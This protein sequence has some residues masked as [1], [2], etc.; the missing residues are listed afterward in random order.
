MRLDKLTIGSAKDSATHKFKNLK[1]VTID[2]DQDHWVTVVIGWNGTG[3][4]NVLEALAIIF[5]DLIAK[6]RISEFAFKLA[7]HMG[8]GENL[9]HIYIDADPDR[10]KEPFT[11]HIAT[12][13]EA[14]GEDNSLPFIEGE[15]SVPALRG[16]EIKFTDFLN[17]DSEHLPRYVFSYY[18]G[19]S[20]RMHEVFRPYLESYDSKL[21]NGEDPGLKRLFYAM[22][23]HSQ[24]VLLAFLI[25]QSDV[26][27]TFLDDHLGLDPD[28]G[29]ESVLFVL[30]QP[31]WKSEAVDGDPRFWNA[32]GVVRDFLSRLYDIA[33]AP[34]EVSR[35]VSTSIW[36][37]KKLQFKY[38]Y[39]K[40]IAALR[41]LVGDQAPAQFFR[42]LEST[43]VSELIE[44]VRIRV[45]LKKNDGSVTF[46]ELSEGE[47][48]LLTV[49]GLLRFTAEEESLFLLDEPDTHL[50]PRWCV[51]YLNYLKSF[52]GQ[53]SK[54]DDNS[55][56]ILTTHNPLAIAELVKEQVQIL[57]RE[58]GSRTVRA[59]NPAVDPKGMG[60]AGIVTSDMFGLGTS[61]D[62]AT[63]DDLMILHQLSTQQ[64]PLNE[65][66]RSKL[67]D[68]RQRLEGLDF[69]FASRDRLEQEYLRARFDLATDG[70]VDG[71]VITPENKQQALDV[72]VQSLL[73]SLKDGQS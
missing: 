53:N 26:V 23:V 68:I 12:D 6:K 18:S 34:I 42:D 5:R 15:E 63:N 9:R 72:L 41:R 45:R 65:A 48:Q 21:R 46:R 62:K 52:V 54:G 33:L 7:Y 70:V 3:K 20:P 16:K 39:V 36:N 49:L 8:S 55:H 30:R 37:K 50:N 56:I 25:Q 29:I 11:V 19:E 38:L 28:E 13:A 27:R 1:N 67:A 69:N 24:F 10:E 40:D 44:E 59:E 57:Y 31:P 35:R 60:F 58:A 22:P 14:R 64:Q 73:R 2:F 47:Q 17:A 61:L 51:D 43:Y 66:E 32:R 71:A 4:S